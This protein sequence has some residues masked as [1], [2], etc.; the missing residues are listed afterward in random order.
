MEVANVF[1]TF[2]T[3]RIL[4]QAFPSWQLGADSRVE[5]NKAY[6]NTVCTG[7][8]FQPIDYNLQKNNIYLL[9]R[10]DLYTWYNL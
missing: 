9:S 6:I 5:I 10:H 2:R 8:Y 7:Y 1:N 4:L 3:W